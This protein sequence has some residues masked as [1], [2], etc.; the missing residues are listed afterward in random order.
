MLVVSSTHSDA[1]VAS[2]YLGCALPHT[3]DLGRVLHSCLRFAYSEV[4]V[5]VAV[6]GPYV[7]TSTVIA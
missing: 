4:T 6:S 5:G 1:L 3:L 2:P 7:H